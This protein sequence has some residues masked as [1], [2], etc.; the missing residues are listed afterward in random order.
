VPGLDMLSLGPEI[1]FPHSPDER[2]SVPTVE[3]FW[4]LLV[5]LVDELSAAGAAP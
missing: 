5:G 3:R 1:Q 4:R 2:I